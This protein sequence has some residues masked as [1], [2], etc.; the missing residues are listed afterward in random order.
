MLTLVWPRHSCGLAITTFKT[1]YQRMQDRVNQPFLDS[2][3]TLG[4]TVDILT[5][6]NLIYLIYDNVQVLK[7]QNTD[8]YDDV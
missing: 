6:D 7:M 5:V 3:C 4:F 2:Y 8:D 1:P